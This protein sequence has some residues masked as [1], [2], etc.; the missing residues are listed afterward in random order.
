MSDSHW[1]LLGKVLIG[2]VAAVIAFQ[3]YL[4]AT[5]PRPAPL[6]NVPSPDVNSGKA[7]RA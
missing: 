5:A 7:A 4:I 3:I 1:S 6:M 2:P